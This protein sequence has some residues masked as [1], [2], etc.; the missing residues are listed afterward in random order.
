[1]DEITWALEWKRI[2]FLLT[3]GPLTWMFLL[4]AS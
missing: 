1:M 3:F 4:L 2:C